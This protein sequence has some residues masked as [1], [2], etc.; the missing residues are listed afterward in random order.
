MLTDQTDRWSEGVPSDE[1][2]EAARQKV[3]DFVSRG[4]EA[5]LEREGDLRR[6]KRV[7]QCVS[8]A[9]PY[10]AR[11]PC[12]QEEYP[13]LQGDCGKPTCPLC[14]HQTGRKR[15][16]RL[17][18]ALGWM[19][20]GLHVTTTMPRWMS[21]KTSPEKASRLLGKVAK[22]VQG[23]WGDLKP[24]GVTVLHLTGDKHPERPHVHYHTFLSGLCLAKNGS[25]ALMPGPELSGRKLDELRDRT[26]EAMGVPAGER[27]M[28]YEYREGDREITHCIY[29]ICRAQGCGDPVGA[30]R[31]NVYNLTTTRP[32]GCIATG[33]RKEWMGKVLPWPCSARDRWGQPVSEVVMG[34]K[35]SRCNVN[36]QLGVSN[37]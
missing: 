2:V 13:L 36:V 16:S 29:Y 37:G 31:W 10:S 1:S 23:S 27:Q 11:C 17:L 30:W 15:A 22:A 33:K 9:I 25:I 18:D 28:Q 21:E 24:A 4:M 26:G 35:C 14:K 7:R 32:L 19:P 6:W 20:H 3:L 12:C 34:Q 8:R 5:A